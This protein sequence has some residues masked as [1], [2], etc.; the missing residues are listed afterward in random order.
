VHRIHHLPKQSLH[1]RMH[2]Q[3]RM[4]RRWLLSGVHLRRSDVGDGLRLE[5][6]QLL[7]RYVLRL[8]H[9]GRVRQWRLRLQDICGLPH[10]L[11]V[12]PYNAPVLGLLRRSEQHLQHRLL[13]QRWVVRSRN[14]PFGGRLQRRKVFGVHDWLQDG[15]AWQMCAKSHCCKGR[16]NLHFEHVHERSQPRLHCSQR[17]LRSERRAARQQRSPSLVRHR[18]RLPAGSLGVQLRLRGKQ[19]LPQSVYPL[20]TRQRVP[21]VSGSLP[22]VEQVTRGRRGLDR[23]RW[24]GGRSRDSS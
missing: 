17:V 2:W 12:Q 19:G 7:Q 1:R 13:Q 14:I 24:F 21:A 23:L 16:G 5:L 22:A 15:R 6:Y 20:P 11:R 4:R 18:R 10:E 3:C 9:R 8:D